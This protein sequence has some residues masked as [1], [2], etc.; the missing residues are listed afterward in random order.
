MDKTG[1]K[2]FLLHEKFAGTGC[3]KADKFVTTNETG[4][5]LGYNR[6]TIWQINE[7]SLK[8]FSLVFQNG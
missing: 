7:T 6:F 8:Q 5:S 1:L 3:F 4:S 2:Q